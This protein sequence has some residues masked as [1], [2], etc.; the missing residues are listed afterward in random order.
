MALLTAGIPPQPYGAGGRKVSLPV[1]ATAQIYEGSLVSQIAGACVATST[2]S[3]G[4]VVGV[5]EHDMLGGASDGTK[6]I[7]V[8]TDQ[9]F[10]F[11]NGTAAVADTTPYGTLLY[12]EDDHTV[13]L[14][15]LG[16]TQQIV[17]RFV[18]FED[19]GR[20]RVFISESGNPESFGAFTQQV[21]G[22]NIPN[23]ASTTVQRVGRVSRYLVAALSQTTTVTL[24]TTGA[25]V[26]DYMRIIR[27][28]AS[29]FTLAI[30]NGGGGA[31]T[32][33]TLVASKIGF[34]EAWFDGTNWL[35][36][37]CSAT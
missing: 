27:T 35:F 30:V 37:G 13:G 34:A 19:D 28:D 15:G 14:G 23:A 9:I 36:E 16:A 1:K 8:L 12:A 26:G 6:R 24:G 18:G 25:V 17:G 32:L 5:A 2:A 3:G 33:C 20:V 31:G 22:T 10:L 4:A 21:S 7:S 29:A 11:P